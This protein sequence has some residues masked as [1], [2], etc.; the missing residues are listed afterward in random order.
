MLFT[1]KM[2]RLQVISRYDDKGKKVS[3]E[4]VKIPQT[5]CDLPY[6]TAVAYQT[7]FPDADVKIEQQYASAP[8]KRRISVGERATKPE[9]RKASYPVESTRGSKKPD[10]DSS[11]VRDAASGNLAS[12]L[13]AEMEKA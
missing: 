9:S 10:R 7:K 2:N 3:E 1:V 6:Q 13:T 8:E 11:T 5:Y 12:A 4:I